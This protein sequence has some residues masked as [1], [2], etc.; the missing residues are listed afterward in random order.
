MATKL[1]SKPDTQRCITALRAQGIVVEKLNGGYEAILAG[2]EVFKAMQ[3]T[4]GYLVR[5]TDDLFVS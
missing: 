3:G 1:W 2:K 4:R 5:Y